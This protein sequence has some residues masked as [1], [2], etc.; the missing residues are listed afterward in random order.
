MLPNELLSDPSFH[1]SLLAIDRELASE[2]RS[3]GCKC[4][5]RL[6]AAHYPRRTRGLPDGLGAEHHLRF[7]FCCSREGCRVRATPPSVRF[8]GRRVYGGGCLLLAS[9]VCQ[10]LTARSIA[11]LSA[12]LGIS[13]R[14]LRRWRRW[15][16]EELP[17]TPFWKGLRGWLVPGFDAHRLP[18]TLLDAFPDAHLSERLVG[19]LRLLAPLGATCP[20]LSPYARGRR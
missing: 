13:R 19:A 6:D 16:D 5:G 1:E 18:T 4:G 9:A 7:S 8:L 3:R 11:R 17:T 15:W 12:I 10:G 20:T 14:T 2:V